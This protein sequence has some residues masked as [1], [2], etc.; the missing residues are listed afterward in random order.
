M[1]ECE[2]YIEECRKVSKE[3]LVMWDRNDDSMW[4]EEW[5]CCSGTHQQ[6]ENSVGGIILN[7]FSTIEEAEK[8]I[9][10]NAL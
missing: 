6:L 7:S 4:I 5:D 3:Y 1:K 2:N 10:E 9:L 8:Y